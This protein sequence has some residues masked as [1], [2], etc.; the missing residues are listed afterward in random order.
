MR[1]RGRER[2]NRQKYHRQGGPIAECLQQVAARIHRKEPLLLTCCMAD[3]LGRGLLAS[4]ERQELLKGDARWWMGKW[5][6]GMRS[7]SGGG[8][9]AQWGVAPARLRIL[10]YP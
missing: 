5:G 2:L 3:Q 1:Y 9:A 10:K 7:A 4:Q 8:L 6:K